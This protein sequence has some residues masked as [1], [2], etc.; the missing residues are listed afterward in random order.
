MPASGMHVPT[1]PVANDSSA[2]QPGNI[3]YSSTQVQLRY[4]H[5]LQPNTAFLPGNLL[6]KSVRHGPWA[7]DA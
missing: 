4:Q 1:W 6:L 7:M 5:N 2:F 3:T